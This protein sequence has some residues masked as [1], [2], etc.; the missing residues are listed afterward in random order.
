[1]LALWP[2][3][4][5]LDESVSMLDPESR[6]DIFEFLEYWNKSG[7]TIIHITHEEDAINHA[8]NVLLLE[9]GQV[10]YYGKKTAFLQK[11]EFTKNINKM[12]SYMIKVEIPSI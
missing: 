4:L 3:I 12:Y 8:E 5:I 10:L 2:E 6:K 9:K 7:N 1:M 11:E